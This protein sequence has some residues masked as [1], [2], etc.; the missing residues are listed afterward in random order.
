METKRL[1]LRRFNTGDLPH[2]IDLQQIFP[3]WILGRANTFVRFG[4]YLWVPG[5]HSERFLCKDPV[6]ERYIGF[7]VQS[8]GNGP[9]RFYWV[10]EDFSGRPFKHI[11]EKELHQKGLDIWRRCR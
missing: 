9:Y 4:D 5:R 7:S 8:G 11:P 10:D 6:I 2:W 1:R 3:N